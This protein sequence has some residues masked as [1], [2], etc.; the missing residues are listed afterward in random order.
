MPIPEHDP[1]AV[2]PVVR[3]LQIIVA[4]LAMGVV[5]FLVI[6]AL[7]IPRIVPAQGPPGGGAPLEV[8]GK[9]IQG[10]GMQVITLAAIAL[11]VS[12]LAMSYV[13]P[14]MLVAQGRRQIA[15]ERTITGE[16]AKLSPT[17]QASD[18]G[19]LLG[20]YQNH[21]IVGAAL[22]E[23]GAFFAG[24]AYMLERHSLALLVALVL[25][26]AILTRFPTRDRLAAWL[27]RQLALVQ[28]ERQAG[29]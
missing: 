3:T 27:D 25:I 24:I 1:E 11:G 19:R 10:G 12:S 14:G 28:E 6:V 13:I 26:G 20:L 17:A 2:E 8:F 7:F 16:P 18:A 5:M 23:G 22:A 4:S 15:R 21:L 29:F 9:Q